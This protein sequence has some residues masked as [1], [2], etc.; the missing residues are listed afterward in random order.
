MDL[1]RVTRLQIASEVHSSQA[2][3]D[4]AFGAWAGLWS[5]EVM[6]GHIS[7]LPSEILY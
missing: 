6:G 3:L 1:N 4:V 7:G 2:L 5:Y